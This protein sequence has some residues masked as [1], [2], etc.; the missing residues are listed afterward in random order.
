MVYNVFGDSL[1]DCPGVNCASNKGVRVTYAA[2]H[3][4]NTIPPPRWPRLRLRTPR[5][6]SSFSSSSTTTT[7]A[8]LG[9]TSLIPHSSLCCSAGQVGNETSLHEQCSRTG[10]TQRG[11]WHRQFDPVRMS[12]APHPPENSAGPV[13]FSAPEGPSASDTAWIRVDAGRLR[14]RIHLAG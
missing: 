8:L 2:V 11:I 13:V 14:Q 4:V 6:T 12:S 9:A 3:L 7:T 5:T 1:T 10:A